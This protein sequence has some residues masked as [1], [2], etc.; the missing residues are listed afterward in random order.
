MGKLLLCKQEIMGHLKCGK[1]AFK[2]WI[3]RGLPA[4]YEDGR[5][6]AHTDNV[7]EFLRVWTK[8]KVGG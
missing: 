4:R 5:W 1:Y 8:E 3:E 6:S 7:D 2:V